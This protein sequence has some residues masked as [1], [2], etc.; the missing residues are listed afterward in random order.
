[1]EQGYPK[2]GLGFGPAGAG[3][4]GPHG[5]GGRTYGGVPGAATWTQRVTGWPQDGTRG[6]AQFL[7]ISQCRRAQDTG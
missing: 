1:M 7:D 6:L 3:P 5:A 4:L 2:S